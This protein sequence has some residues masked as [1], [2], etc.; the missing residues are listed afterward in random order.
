[1]FIDTG[2]KITTVHV[3][4]VPKSAYTG[5]YP[6]QIASTGEKTTYPLAKVQLTVLDQTSEQLV[7]V[8]PNLR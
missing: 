2:C 5:E 1:M 3:K 4:L 8:D 6:K 7:N